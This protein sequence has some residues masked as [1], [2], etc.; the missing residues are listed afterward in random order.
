MPVWPCAVRASGTGKAAPPK[1]SAS[2]NQK[3]AG[4]RVSV[5]SKSSQ[6]KGETGCY[7]S[8]LQRCGRDAR[9]RALHLLDLPP[10]LLLHIV[11]ER[12]LESQVLLQV[13][14]AR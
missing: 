4:E 6:R 7:R 14:I 5:L 13:L 1:S 3:S 8:P 2:I 11:K 10:I 9:A 12:V